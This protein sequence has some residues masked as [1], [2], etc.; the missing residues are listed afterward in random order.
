MI[1]AD[2]RAFPYEKSEKKGQRQKVNCFLKNMSNYSAFGHLNHFFQPICGLG[3]IFFIILVL[4]LER[5]IAKKNYVDDYYYYL[6]IFDTRS[7]KKHIGPNIGIY[8]QNLV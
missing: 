5:K 7:T 8:F 4:A 2:S 1:N 6:F 3:V